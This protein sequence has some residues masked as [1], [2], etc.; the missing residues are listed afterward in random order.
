M[1]A[2][3]DRQAEIMDDPALEDQQHAAALCGLQRIHAVSGT[4]GRM[5]RP[6]KQLLATQ[7]DQ[8]LRV[9]DVGCGDGLLLRQLYHCARRHG[10]TLQ[11]VGCDFSARALELA[12]KAAGRERV[13][14]E[15]QQIDVTR[16]ALPAPVDVVI[17][18]LFLHHFDD[19]DVPQILQ[20]FARAARRSV[21][22]EDLLRSRLGLGL[23]WC[24]VR[25]LTRSPVV[26]VDGPLSVRAAFKMSEMRGLLARAGWTQAT[27]TKYW[28][29]RFF[30]QY[31]PGVASQSAVEDAPPLSGGPHGN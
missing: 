30:I 22:I 15:L 26:H 20:Q 18:S 27:L 8:Q 19:G 4:L 21:L 11:L 23:C 14:L 7:P 5:W 25:L 24:G 6:L 16:Q 31:A 9:M 2:K 3:R 28:P 29:E 12:E 1:L 10:Y 17:N 13:P